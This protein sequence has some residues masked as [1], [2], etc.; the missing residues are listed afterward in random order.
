MEVTLIAAMSKNRVIGRDNGLIWHMPK[1]LKRFK[2]LTSGHHVIMGRK[3]FES[4][5]KPLPNRINIVITRQSDYHAPGC[6][7]V[8]TMEEALSKAEGDA[9]PYVIGGGEIYKMSLPYAR[10][11]E[12]TLVQEN[13]DGDTYFPEWDESQWE[14]IEQ[15]EHKPDE[16][17]PY[18]FQYLTYQKK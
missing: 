16:N 6:L 1:D 4:M 15:E 9:K 3:T 2:K 14:L 11:I 13:F 8:S 17:N 18:P 7:V 5:N 12:L 10:R